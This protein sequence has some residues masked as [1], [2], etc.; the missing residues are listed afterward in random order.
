MRVALELQ[1][2]CS[3]RSGIGIYTYELVKRM[4]EDDYLSF[5]GNLFK[6]FLMKNDSALQEIRF[7]I[8]YIKIMPYGIY[9]RIWSVLPVSYQKMFPNGA[10]ITHFFNYIVP[11]G[12]KG[13]V[14]DTVYDLVFL[15]YP[16]TMDKRNLARISKGLV[17][18]LEQ[19][20]A[21]ITDSFF[22]K[23]E[24][25]RQYGIKSDIIHVVYPAAS[26]T[27]TNITM[28]EITKKWNI[29]IPYI[30]YVGNIEPRK[31]LER[32]INA[33][34]IFRKEMPGRIQLVLAGGKGWCSES[35]YKSA[36]NSNYCE[37]IVFTGYVSDEEKSA[38]YKNADLFVFP[39]IYEGFGIPVLEAMECSV[40]VVCSGVSSLPEVIGGN[41]LFVNPFSVQDIAEK[42]IIG[43]SD[44]KLAEKQAVSAKARAE[45]FSWDKSAQKLIEIYKSMG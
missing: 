43:I 24:I 32:L 4:H 22:I 26:L 29:K 35:I 14:I 7:P 18:S 9:R 41:A 8:D 25:M 10:D 36:E 27:E 1:P 42:L 20:D 11:P 45:L 13:K 31:N 34:E 5:R 38:L 15:R 16:E 23:E 30:L 21:I 17:R 19:S 3:R 28:P 33:Y 12:V 40:P 37:D 39:S 44:R 2:C 6:F